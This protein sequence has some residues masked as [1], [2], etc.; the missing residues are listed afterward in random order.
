MKHHEFPHVLFLCITTV[1]LTIIECQRPSAGPPCSASEV[2]DYFVNPSAAGFAALSSRSAPPYDT[3]AHAVRAGHLQSPTGEALGTWLTDSAG[4][5]YR[6]GYRT[7]RQVSADTTYPL[8]IYLHGGTGSERNDKGDSAFFMLKDLA[9]TFRLF[10]A[11]PSANRYT[12]WWSPEGLSRILQTLRF[13]TLHYPVNPDKV[14]LAGVSDGATGCYAAA[15]T[16]PGPFAGFIAVSGFGGMLQQVGMQLVPGNLM[17]RPIY[18]VNAG[19]D[20]IYAVDMVR[21]FV[22]DLQS[23]GVPVTAKWYENELHGFDYRAR[24]MGTLATLIRMWSKPA[25]QGISW[26]FVPGFPNL[27]DNILSWDYSAINASASG[28]WRND[29]LIL[30]TKGL[31]SL[32]LAFPAMPAVKKVNCHL[33]ADAEKEQT[34]KLSSVTIGWPERLQMLMHNGIPALNEATVFF[35][36]P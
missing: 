34:F 6:L 18:N 32:T 28:F 22:A 7:P 35:V 4:Q 12:P 25:F 36:K 8:I 31:R 20:R 15:N 24:E 33:L 29:S 26:T 30:Q 17:R 19:L 3:L 10:L 1:C 2:T 16:I 11:S 23:Q 13:M 27:P 21:S 14:F 5:T 9:D